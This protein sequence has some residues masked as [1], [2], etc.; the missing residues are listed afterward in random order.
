MK[1][2]DLN[3]VG[4]LSHGV[5]KHRL[6]RFVADIRCDGGTLKCHVA[7][8][9]RLTEIL[10]PGRPILIAMNPASMK[11]DCRLI[12]CEM[13]EGWIL[14]NTGLH[15]RI[16]RS[17]ITAGGLGFV[18]ETVRSE[19]PVAHSR[20]DFLLDDELFVEVK[21]VNLLVDGTMQFPDAPTLR[22]RRHLETLIQLVHNGNRAMVLML[23]LRSG[24]CFRPHR[25]T[26]P[27]FA[28]TFYR[29]LASGV[30]YHGM[31]ATVDSSDWSVRYAG[32][33]PL[34]ERVS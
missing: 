24:R 11:T 5:F 32:K 25:E 10:T 18:P 17:F 30:G 4:P 29:A 21:G 9:G 33:L 22:G 19:V 27:A 7:D 23:A 28:D 1:L 6:N 8:T 2:L 13:D 14:V 34:C 16:V 26:D 20:L 15:S 3:T 12:A 31:R